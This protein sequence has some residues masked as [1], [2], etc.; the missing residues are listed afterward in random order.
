MPSHFAFAVN[1]L[2]RYPPPP[3][4]YSQVI[5]RVLVVRKY[6][7]KYIALPRPSFLR[8]KSL[9]DHPDDQGRRAFVKYD[10]DPFYVRPTLWNRWG[11]SAWLPRLRGLPLPGDDGDTYHPGGY[12][13]PEIGPDAFFGK[14]KAEADETKARLLKERTG[15]CPFA[16]VR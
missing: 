2:P 10:A 12:L 16:V 14:G 5:E 6:V 11:P 9:E 4:I 15:G 3:T 7:L 8:Y 13:I 1:F